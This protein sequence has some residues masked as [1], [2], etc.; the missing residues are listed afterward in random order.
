MPIIAPQPET[1]KKRAVVEFQM[2][3]MY[4]TKHRIVEGT[5]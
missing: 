2:M 3:A 1:P 5:D 4:V